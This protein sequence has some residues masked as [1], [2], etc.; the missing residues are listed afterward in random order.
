MTQRETIRN[1]IDLR[2]VDQVWDDIVFNYTG[3]DLTQVILYNQ[4]VIVKTVN[5]TWA[6]GVVTE[7]ETIYAD[8]RSNIVGIS[9]S[10]G[11]VS[12]VQKTETQA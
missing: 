3:S 2:L 5:L 1:Y 9:Y 7:V 6:G 10:S 12:G 11:S 4:S 8:G